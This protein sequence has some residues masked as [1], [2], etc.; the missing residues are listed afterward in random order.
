MDVTE[1][2][3]IA[4]PDGTRL[5]GRMWRP[6]GPGPFPSILEII[7]YRRRD[8]TRL[9]DDTLHPRF[10]ESGYVALRVDMRGT[11]D[12]DGLIHGEYL[13]REI[14]DSVDVIAWIAAQGWSD[15][16]V[17]MVGKSWG[18]FACYQV[19]ARRPP[20]LRAIAPVMGTDD[21]WSE[22]IH[23]S[24]GCL[25]TDNFWWGCIMQ[26]FN[27]QP[28]DPDV[29]GE[30]WLAIWKTRLEAMTFWPAEWLAHQTRDA[31]WRHGSVCEEYSAIEVPVYAWGGWADA[32]RNTIFR[33]AEHLDA[34]F[35]A[36]IGPWG[37]LYPHDGAPGPQVDFPAELIRWWDHW[38]K[39]RDSGL[40][41]EPALRF[42]LQEPVQPGTLP[43]NRAGHWIGMPGWPGPGITR[44]T[45]WLNSGTLDADAGSG[46][47]RS[48]TTPTSYGQ[49]GGDVMSFATPG[50]LPLDGRLD[51]AGALEFR[52]PVARTGM[53]ILGVPSLA[54]RIAADRPQAQVAALLM[55][56]A[57]DGTQSVISRG[58]ANLTHHGGADRVTLLTPG[59]P[60]EITL[61]MHATS[62]RLPAGH[63][64]LLKLSSGYWPILWPGPA[65]T[66]ITIA[67][68]TCALSL[69]VHDAPAGAPHPRPL[70]PPEPPAPAAMTQLREGRMER[71]WCV[72]A[73]TG[74]ITNRVWIDG[75]VFGPVGRVRLDDTGTEMGDISERLHEI[76]RDPLSARATMTQTGGFAREGWTPGWETRAEMTAGA[77]MF[78]LRASV[79]CTLDGEEVF[80]TEWAHDIPRNGM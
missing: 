78:R 60:V 25:R 32:Y 57:P 20:A 55:D 45:L 16:Q 46:P 36:V 50:D 63:R 38:M 33:L 3:W 66:A 75:G 76:G 24:G 42:F 53:T 62:A 12:S 48:I 9:R 19:A 30:D 69:P 71:G 64:L 74:T 77:G 15:G 2:I 34:P 61:E 73:M 68:G 44:Q 29:V 40:M 43:T 79:R 37:H 10:A 6:D 8:R 54:L 52:G 18:A 23:I 41:E 72:D 67:P 56:E 59:E 1:T 26:L 51:G 65:L 80:F 5:A 49:A 4:L 70:P 35:K 31:F 22:D 39:G 28:P 47:A 14:R 17:G 58:Y 7:P 11:G 27:A 21:R 13:E